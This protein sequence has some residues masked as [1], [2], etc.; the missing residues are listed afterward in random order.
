M[1]RYFT[2]EQAER[3]LPE[4]ERLLRDALYH[5]SEAQKAHDEL[6]GQT[7]RIRMSGGVRVDHGKLL[8]MQSRRD[9]STSALQK[10]LEG[11]TELGAQVK[12][13]DIGLIDFPTLF[14]EREVCLCWKL[15]EKSIAYWH[16][17]E[18]GFRGRK[19][20]DDTFRAGHRGDH[21]H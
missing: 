20:I 19:P 7:Q 1:P 5:K 21:R 18:D 4:V 6:E 12:D 10:A 16:S 8:D 17:T 2:L 9:S 15:G 3:N 14:D 13:L 11:V